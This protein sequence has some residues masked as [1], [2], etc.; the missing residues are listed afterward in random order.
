MTDRLINKWN[1][2]GFVSEHRYYKSLT[3]IDTENPPLPTATIISGL[4]EYIDT[5]ITLNTWYY[6]CVSSIKNGV[7][8]FSPV[9]K[10]WAG[11]G[12]PYW[13]NVVHLLHLNS[14]AY[15]SKR[16]QN[17]TASSATYQAGKF[18]NGF[19][20]DGISLRKLTAPSYVRLDGDVTIEFNLKTITNNPEY[21]G[22]IGQRY[23]GSNSDWAIVVMPNSSVV[24]FEIIG[25]GAFEFPAA[26]HGN[27]IDYAIEIDATD[28]KLR[29]YMEGNLIHEISTTGT[30]K[31]SGYPT[32]IG[33]LNQSGSELYRMNAILDEVRITKGVCRY[34]GANYIPAIGP[35]PD[36]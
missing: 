2:D 14:N 4:T 25:V 19:R 7:E 23:N 30:V 6:T 16:A 22:I 33:T 21:G 5:D 18:G 9:R 36:F 15:D 10:T 8:K 11:A 31:N 26:G 29:G 3:P 32:R 34:K 12:D 1:T 28:R 27:P 24:L 35:F 20:G 13:A 17:W